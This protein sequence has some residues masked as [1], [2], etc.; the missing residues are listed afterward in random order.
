MKNKTASKQNPKV[1]IT[2]GILAMSF[3]PIALFA[4]VPVWGE[5]PQSTVTSPSSDCS[6]NYDYAVYEWQ[7]F[8]SYYRQT[9]N[10]L[11]SSWEYFPDINVKIYNPNGLLWN[12]VWQNTLWGKLPAFKYKSNGRPG[13]NHFTFWG[14]ATVYVYSQDDNTYAIKP[15]PNTTRTTMAA[16]IIHDFFRKQIASRWGNPYTMTYLPLGSTVSQSFTATPSAWYGMKETIKCQNFYIAKCG[17]SIVD[18][19]NKTGDALTDGLSGILV[20]GMIVHW[21]STDFTWEVCDDGNTVDGDGCNATCSGVGGWAAYCGD[22][23]I[24]D[25]LTDTW[26][27]PTYFSGWIEMIE[28]CDDWPRDDITSSWNHDGYQYAACGSTYCELN[29]EPEQLPEELGQ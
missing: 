28:Q 5:V 24:N 20:N 3:F 8:T 27:W 12:V 6:T 18:N 11:A 29:T 16:Q 13:T 23:I 9:P 22:S 7:G 14:V 2:I 17:D 1:A 21:R 19:A 4:N 15:N 26:H 10:D 25:G